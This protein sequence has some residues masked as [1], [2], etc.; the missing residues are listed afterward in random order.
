MSDLLQ[1]HCVPCED[2]VL[3]MQIKEAQALMNEVPGW[4]LSREAQLLNREYIFKNFKDALAFVNKVGTIAE[5]EGHHP[6]I[7][8]GWGK[9]HIEI[10]TH[11]IN[12]LS[13]SDFVLAAKISAL[14]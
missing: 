11:K 5:S 1:K 14:V 10:W 6:D 8:L 7:Y 4:T 3:P 2:G 9:V 13:V 12:G